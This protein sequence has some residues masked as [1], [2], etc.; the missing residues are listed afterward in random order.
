MSGVNRTSGLQKDIVSLY[1]QLLRCAKQKNDK[2]LFKFVAVEFRQKSKQ[3]GKYDFKAIEHNLRY[4]NKQLSM[5]R[6]PGF[7]TASYNFTTSNQS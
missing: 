6:M 3:V 4:G 2:G 5:M 1:R 7:M